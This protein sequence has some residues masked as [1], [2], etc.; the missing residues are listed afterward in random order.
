MRRRSVVGIHALGCRHEEDVRR[1]LLDADLHAVLAEIAT[2]QESVT[3]RLNSTV[4]GVDPELP[5]VT[6]AS[7]E[8]VKGDLVIGADGLKS[9]VRN[10][11]I[12]H[13]E[14][15]I[16]TGDSAYRAVI[17]TV[18]IAKDLELMA[19]FRASDTNGWLSGTQHVVAY[20]VRAKKE[21]NLVLVH[22][23]DESVESWTAVSDAKKMMLEFSGFEPRVQKIIAQ[24]KTPLTWRL[25]DRNPLETWV[26]P[27][28]RVTLL[29]DACHPI[30][31]HRALGT[32]MAIEDAAALGNILSHLSSQDQLPVFLKT[33]QSIRHRLASAA[34]AISRMSKQLLQIPPAP[35]DAAMRVMKGEDAIKHVEKDLDGGFAPLRTY[36]VVNDTP[37]ADEQKEIESLL[38]DVDEAVDK[39]WAEEGERI[40]GGTGS[41][42]A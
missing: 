26:Q 10:I 22:Q 38:C 35:H 39:W 12:G 24:I 28:G 14:C 6:L 16:A 17:S 23:D 25:V 15:P 1:A 13:P 3:V 41:K 30:L 32:V 18:F 27:R 7:G 34:Q 37:G 36:A 20:E 4:V 40:V 29:G 31:P 11:V 9:I 19:F 21:L 42:G 5:S 2:K 8:V 33:Y